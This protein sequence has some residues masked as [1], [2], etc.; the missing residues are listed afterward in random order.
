MLELQEYNLTYFMSSESEM[1]KWKADGL[2]GDGLSMQNAIIILNSKRTPMVIDPSSQVRR[3]GRTGGTGQRRDKGRLGGNRGG[4]VGQGLDPPHC[5]HHPYCRA[6][7]VR[8]AAAGCQR[9]REG[10][11]CHNIINST[12]HHP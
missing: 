2:P 6:V 8:G 10:S 7:K 5:L 3:R 4:W 1:L 11:R 12:Q 9:P